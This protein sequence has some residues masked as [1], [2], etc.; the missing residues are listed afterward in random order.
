MPSAKVMMAPLASTSLT[1]PRFFDGAFIVNSHVVGERIFF[2]CLMP[3]MRSRSGSTEDH[4]F[5]LV[6]LAL[7]EAAYSFIAYFVP[8]CVD[9]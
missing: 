3:R 6:S 5:Q 4:G 2:N 1:I 9:R 7:L 8:G